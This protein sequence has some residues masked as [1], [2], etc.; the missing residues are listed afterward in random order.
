MTNLIRQLT[1]LTQFF[2]YG[3][4]FSINLRWWQVVDNLLKNIDIFPASVFCHL[5][6]DNALGIFLQTHGFVCSLRLVGGIEVV[7]TTLQDFKSQFV[8]NHLVLQVRSGEKFFQ[9]LESTSCVFP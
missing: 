5:P 9:L 2:F 4:I 8:G 7:N 1:I 6:N 3:F